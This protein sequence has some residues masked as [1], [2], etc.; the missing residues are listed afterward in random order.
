MREAQQ[1]SG[2]WHAHFTQKSEELQDE[3]NA[4]DAERQ[5]HARDSARMRSQHAAELAA[6]RSQHAAELAAVRSQHATELEAVRAKP[7]VFGNWSSM[8]FSV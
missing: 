5:C 7:A 2:A 6:V 8:A 4:F 1:A 3:R